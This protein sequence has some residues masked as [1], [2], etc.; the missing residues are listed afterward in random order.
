FRFVPRERFEKVDLATILNDGAENLSIYLAPEKGRY[1]E[2]LSLRI[3]SSL[4]IIGQKPNCNCLWFEKRLP[5]SL[6][7]EDV[8]P[9]FLATIRRLPK[10]H[11]P[12]DEQAWVRRLIEF[13]PQL[14]HENG[15]AI[16][17]PNRKRKLIF[18]LGP[19]SK[20]GYRGLI[21]FDRR[22]IRIVR[23][24]EIVTIQ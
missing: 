13:E 16:Q 18:V 17:A 3:H 11:R 5:D 1:C 6:H 8:V 7:T 10:K 15:R 14:A 20:P 22:D 21:H 19:V 4:P 9:W 2:Y 24:G 23:K 12:H